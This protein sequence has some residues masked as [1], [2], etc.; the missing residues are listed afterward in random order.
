YYCVLDEN[1]RKTEEVMHSNESTFQNIVWQDKGEVFAFV[2]TYKK[3]TDNRNDKNLYVYS[4]TDKVVFE[5]DVNS[6]PERNELTQLMALKKST[7]VISDDAQRVFFY[8]TEA[9]ANP[10]EKPVVQLWNGND[11]WTYSQIMNEIYQ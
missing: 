7:L 3:R 4:V 1:Q 10:I 2:K 5:L 8:T 11:S 6:I 9:T